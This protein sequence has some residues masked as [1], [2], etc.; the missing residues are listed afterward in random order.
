LSLAKVHY[1]T[2]LLL[3]PTALGGAIGHAFG[4]KATSLNQSFGPMN[5]VIRNLTVELGLD[6]SFL[7][8]F[9]ILGTVALA[10]GAAML[11][12]YAVQ[13]AMRQPYRATDGHGAL[14]GMLVALLMPPTV[15]WWLLLLGVLVA[16]FL[17]KQ[18]FGGLG[19][20][21]MH[22]AAVGW[23]ILLLSWPHYVTT[24][25]TA[26][27]AAPNQ[28]VVLVTLSGGVVLWAL[29]AIRPQIVLGT[30][31]G[32]ILFALVFQGRLSGGLLDQ[33]LTG[34]AV[35]GAFFIATDSTSSPANR[36]PMWLYGFG[37]GFLIILIRA[38]GIWHDSVPFA[39]LL[40]NVLAPLLDRLQPRVL[41][42][43]TS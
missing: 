17:G 38:F 30:L 39:I 25:G 7:W 34:H 15:P 26:S 36:L 29:G 40:M 19:G 23:L 3:A 2:L 27:I 21:P 4:D 16:V 11:I 20:Y 41:G 18:V 6:S 13:V 9:G 42:G 12:E 22:P 8:L 35:L 31:G 28:A 33:V 43:A 14:I 1:A 37:T 5:V 24:V 32:V 10:V